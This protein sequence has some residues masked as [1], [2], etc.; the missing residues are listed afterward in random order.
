MDKSLVHFCWYYAAE[1]MNA[2]LMSKNKEDGIVKMY[3]SL[4]M[5]H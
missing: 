3:R 5:L 2:A 4:E 1:M